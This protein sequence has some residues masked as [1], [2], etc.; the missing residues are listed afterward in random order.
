MTRQQ[1]IA[2]LAQMEME[3]RAIADKVP[4]EKLEREFLQ[5]AGEAAELAQDA[6]DETHEMEW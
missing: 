3:L 6:E 4:D 1:I 5:L 2:R